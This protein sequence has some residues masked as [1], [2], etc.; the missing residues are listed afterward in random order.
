MIVEREGMRVMGT[1]IYGASD[2]L[3]EVEGDVCGEVGCYDKD[4]LLACSDGTILVAHYGKPGA[5]GVWSIEVL[6]KG[7]LFEG[8]DICTSEDADPHS[9]VVRFRDGLKMVRAGKDYGIVR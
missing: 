5:G 3:V 1:R 4:L 7:D 9:D 8:V 6:R 2:D